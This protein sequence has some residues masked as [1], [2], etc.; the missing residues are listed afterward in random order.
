LVL[1]LSEIAKIGEAAGV[2]L[3]EPY[4]AFARAKNTDPHITFKQADACALPFPDNS[5]DR[6]FSMLVLQF[7][8]DGSRAVGEM[9][10]VVRPGGTVTAAVWDEYSGL[11]HFRMLVDTA[12]VLDPAIER[13]LFRP[14][15]AP[16]EM[17]TLWRDL[18]FADVEQPAS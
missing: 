2:D 1:A 8:P 10:R 18:G 13:P 9:R 12:A 3:V 7:V 14:L 5:F 17:A 6:A 4:V 11:P 15:N 16:E